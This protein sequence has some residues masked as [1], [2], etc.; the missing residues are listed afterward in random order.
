MW[1]GHGLLLLRH[2]GWSLP[3]FTPGMAFVSGG[4]SIEVR[5]LEYIGDKHRSVLFLSS[6]CHAYTCVA[7][8]TQYVYAYICMW[9]PEWSPVGG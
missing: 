4:D 8:V 5:S 1:S 3:E 6:Y 7:F 2:S 9:R